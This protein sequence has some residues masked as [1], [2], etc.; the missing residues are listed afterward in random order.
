MLD[1][2][3]KAE[4]IITLKSKQDWISRVPRHLPEK[5]R[6]GE[7][8]VWLDKNGNSVHNGADFESAAVKETYPVNVYR[9]I[10]V[11]EVKK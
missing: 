1:V 6:R 2:T 4:L 9:L 10:S 8:W 11:S 3:I 5:T 7:T